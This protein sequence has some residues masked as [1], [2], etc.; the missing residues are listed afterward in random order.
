MHIKKRHHL[1]GHTSAIYALA[2]GTRPG[3]VATTGGDGIIAEWDIASGGDG[4]L[5]ARVPT[6]V[7]SLCLMPQH[8]LMAAGQMAGGIHI[9]HLAQGEELRLLAKHSESVYA[10]HYDAERGHLLAAS[11]DGHLSVWSVPDF[12]LLHYIELS[13]QNLRTIAPSPDGRLVAVG[14]SAD[15]IHLLDADTLGLVHRFQA[16]ENSVFSLCWMPQQDLLVSGGRDAFLR[17]WDSA[18]HFIPVHAIPAHRFTINDIALSPD[19][20][21]FATAGR[22]KEVKIW[23]SASL[24]LLK[25][26]SHEKHEGHIHSVNRLLWLEEGRVLVSA[27]DDRA[28]MVWEV[29]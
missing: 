3:T 24:E 20:R 26:I 29:D 15:H 2:T 4:K 12:Q 14:C 27:G 5:L 10:L 23:D 8:G 9:L 7:F 28:V 17:F 21:V 22:D 1:T 19:G 11:G 13:K 18:N 6:Q 16:H 25:V